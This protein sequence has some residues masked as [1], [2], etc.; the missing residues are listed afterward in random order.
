MKRSQFREIV[1]EVLVDVIQ[2]ESSASEE[3]KRKGLK[4]KGWGRWADP[5]TG[6]VTH[7]TKDG[8]LVPVQPKQSKQT[9]RPFNPSIP[10]AKVRQSDEDVKTY[11]KTPEMRQLRRMR[12]GTSDR[13]FVD[14]TSDTYSM[15]WSFPAYE[16]GENHDNFIFTK[17]L[18]EPGFMIT[19]HREAENPDTGAWETTSN[20][21]FK[22]DGKETPDRVKKALKKV[23]DLVFKEDYGQEEITEDTTLRSLV[24]KAGSEEKANA[25]VSHLKKN[26]IQ[27][28]ASYPAKFGLKADELDGWGVFVEPSDVQEAARILSS[29][30]KG[31][32]FDPYVSTGK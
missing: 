21:E 12:L 31:L 22:I 15:R 30:A 26:N 23:K 28:R 9:D 29:V 10:L 7:Q 24:V 25:A 2:Q 1:R 14:A 5:K 19:F 17:K 13:P 6:Q 3:A 4:S 11:H 27:A 32:T 18:N 8:R 20:R 16:E